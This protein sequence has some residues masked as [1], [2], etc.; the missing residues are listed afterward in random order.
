MEAPRHV[1]R[2]RAAAAPRPSVPCR[3]C[4]PPQPSPST[5]LRSPR[6][7]RRPGGRAAEPVPNVPRIVR[8]I[9]PRGPSRPQPY[10]R[11]SSPVPGAAFRRPPDRLGS[12]LQPVTRTAPR[13]AETRLPVQSPVAETRH[14][15]QNGDSR[16]GWRCPRPRC[17]AHEAIHLPHVPRR[18]IRSSAATASSRA[19]VRSTA[20][21]IAADSEDVRSVRRSRLTLPASTM[22]F[23]RSSRCDRAAAIAIFSDV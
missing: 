4:P 15:V 9:G 11:S 14:D 1:S 22:T 3:V 10:R 2:R 13:P 17:S 12:W 5:A 20:I 7:G 21:L 8:G 19:S 6:R 18:R 16:Q 23:F